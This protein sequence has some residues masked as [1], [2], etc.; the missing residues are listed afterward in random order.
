MTDHPLKTTCPYCNR[1]NEV[2]SNM[3]DDRHGP[4]PGDASLCISCLFV[5]VFDASLKLVKPTPEQQ[6]AI[7]ADPILREACRF[8]AQ[9]RSSKPNHAP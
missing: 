9:R 2:A 4:L 3:C 1:L 8:I 7:D 5:S 6:R